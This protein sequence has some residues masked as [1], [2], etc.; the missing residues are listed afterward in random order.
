[1]VELIKPLY[2]TPSDSQCSISV[3]VGIIPRDYPHAGK[4]MVT[5][6]AWPL[7]SF[8]EARTIAQAVVEAVNARLGISMRLQ[9]G[10]VVDARLQ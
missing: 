9:D 5:L 7:A 3:D 1:M 10:E 2:D 4:Y 8:S 6:Q